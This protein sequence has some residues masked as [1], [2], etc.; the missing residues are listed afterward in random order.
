MVMTTTYGSWSGR[1]EDSRSALTL[2]DYVDGSLQ[3]EYDDATTGRIAAAY[4]DAINAA[5]PDSVQLCG[6][7]FYGPA[8]PTDDEFDDY[9]TDEGRLDIGAVVES[10]DFWAIVEQVTA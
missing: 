1:V 4:R 9:P 3:D 10:V 8:Y 5:L 2:R 6:D 7:E